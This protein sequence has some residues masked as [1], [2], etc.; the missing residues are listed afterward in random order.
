MI[1]CIIGSILILAIVG[2]LIA[3]SRASSS[4]IEEEDVPG[5]DLQYYCG[6]QPYNS[7]KYN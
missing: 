4:E 1:L 6:E 3:L 5:S 7:Y 2:M